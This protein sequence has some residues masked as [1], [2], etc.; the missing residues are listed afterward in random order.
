MKIFVL[1][2]RDRR[3]ELEEFL[4]NRIERRNGPDATLL[5]TAPYMGKTLAQLSH[6]KELAFEKYP[7]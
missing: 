4:R 1:A 5:G 2:K 3:E 6:E 7:D